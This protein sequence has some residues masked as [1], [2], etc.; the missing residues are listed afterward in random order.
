MVG[1]PIALAVH[2]PFGNKRQLNAT[3]FRISIITEERAKDSNTL[4]FYSFIFG[5]YSSLYSIALKATKRTRKDKLFNFGFLSSQ[6]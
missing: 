6:T 5:H 3:K 4:L 2:A 1:G